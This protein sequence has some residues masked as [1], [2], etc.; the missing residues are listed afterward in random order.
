[1]Y[2]CVL[3]RI[4]VPLPPGKYP[5]VVQ[6][7]NNNKTVEVTFQ[8]VAEAVLASL[9]ANDREE[10]PMFLPSLSATGTTSDRIPQPEIKPG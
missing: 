6:L 1:V 10:S 7:N 8:P 4:A 3:C 5:F 2:F 9:N